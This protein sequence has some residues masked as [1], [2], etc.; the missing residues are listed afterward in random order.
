MKLCAGILFFAL[1]LFASCSK[2]EIRYIPPQPPGCG[3]TLNLQ[4]SYNR[5]IQ[6]IIAKNCSGPTCHNGGNG[7]YDF[8]TYEVVKDRVNN[9][10][11]D[12]RLLLPV[13]DQQ[14]MPQTGPPLYQGTNLDPCDLYKILTWI[15]QGAYNN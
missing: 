1:L 9:G 5:D 7:N 13:T 2:D 10:K 6:P 3:D 15:K 14:H 11:M 8:T 4:Y 12:Y